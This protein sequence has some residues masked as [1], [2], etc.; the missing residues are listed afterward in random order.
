MGV[1]VSPSDVKKI[2][3]TGLDDDQL[4]A[5]ITAASLFVDYH[6]GGRLSEELLTEIER[7]MSAHFIAAGPDPREKEFRIHDVWANLRGETGRGLE[8]SQYGQQA[9]VLDPTGRLK[10]AFKPR[11]TFSVQS[12]Y[13]QLK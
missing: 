2:I 10:N 3:E 4:Y 9:V 11:A 6:L 7:W 13:D 1:R 5:I 8:F 12:E